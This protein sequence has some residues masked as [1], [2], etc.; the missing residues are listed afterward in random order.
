MEKK[1]LVYDLESKS[2]IDAEKYLK[3]MMEAKE[4]AE[5]IEMALY[6]KQRN[7]K[8]P[9]TSK[10]TP[11]RLK[12]NQ[13]IPEISKGPPVEDIIAMDRDAH[14]I[15]MNHY[16]FDR[17]QAF[18]NS[19]KTYGPEKAPRY[20]C[21]TSDVLSKQFLKRHPE[22]DQ[23][24]QIDEVY[25]FGEKFEYELHNLVERYIFKPVYHPQFEC[26]MPKITKTQWDI[27]LKQPELL[28][29][30][31]SSGLGNTDI[32]KT[33][34][35]PDTI[36]TLAKAF[37]C[38]REDFDIDIIIE[39]CRFNEWLALNHL[40]W[41][42]A[43]LLG[44]TTFVS[45]GLAHILVREGGLLTILIEIK[46]EIQRLVDEGRKKGAEADYEREHSITNYIRRLYNNTVYVKLVI[47]DY[48]DRLWCWIV[49]SEPNTVKKPI[50]KNV[51]LSKAP[52]LPKNI[53]KTT[54]TTK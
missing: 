52:Q 34:D 23:A 31:C 20:D 13:E 24:D 25:K 49:E 9:T 32:S 26:T 48:F 19:G 36:T 3:R 35:Y 33:V 12:N 4:E 17:I 16:D 50:K 41:R 1:K 46:K 7:I 53:K 40:Y 37:Y 30:N 38:C 15:I 2:I 22:I 42:I 39:F 14:E 10:V 45:S 8:L 5:R 54:K 51:S 47:F 6:D 18:W 27:L 11:V 44:L 21:P 43:F 29:A 28:K